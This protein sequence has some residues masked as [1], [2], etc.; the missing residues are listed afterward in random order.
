LDG[1]CGGSGL[2]EK[3]YFV[4]VFISACAR[5]YTELPGC[6]IN[7]TDPLH[8][9]LAKILLFSSMIPRLG[10]FFNEV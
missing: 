2:W 9:V 3:S 1:V 5:F 7:A 8:W 4:D 6:E 10:Y